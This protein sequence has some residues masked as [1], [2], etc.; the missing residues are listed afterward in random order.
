MFGYELVPRKEVMEDG[1]VV[2]VVG[3]LSSIIPV[4]Q[5]SVMTIVFFLVLQK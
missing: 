5:D 2:T 3:H 4:P 1:T